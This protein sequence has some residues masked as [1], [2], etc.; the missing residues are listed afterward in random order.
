MFFIH[1]HTAPTVLFWG[2]KFGKFF[3]FQFFPGIQEIVIFQVR[4]L[5]V[6]GKV[7]I[8]PDISLCQ[9]F[10]LDDDDTIGGAASV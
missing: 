2:I 5:D 9:F 8:D 10:T 7:V 1:I 4:E 3:I 6:T